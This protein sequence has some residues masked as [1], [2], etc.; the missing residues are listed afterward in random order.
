MLGRLAEPSEIA[1]SLAAMED[2]RSLILTIKTL[3]FDAGS[4]TF[5]DVR[6]R[7]TCEAGP[8]QATMSCRPSPP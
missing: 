7:Y 1:T 4:A 3:R 5:E 6:E 2:R 8:G